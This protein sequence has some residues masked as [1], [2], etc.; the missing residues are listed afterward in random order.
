MAFHMLIY[1]PLCCTP[2]AFHHL[3]QDFQAKNGYSAPQI[4]HVNYRRSLLKIFIL[5]K[6]YIKYLTFSRLIYYF[7]SKD[8]LW[9]IPM[10]SCEHFSPTQRFTVILTNEK[11]I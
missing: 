1:Q 8:D 5:K 10:D 4:Y 6:K 11:V 3:H 9:H 7:V 2:W